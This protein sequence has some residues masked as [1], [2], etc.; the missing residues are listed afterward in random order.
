[1][2][3]RH[4]PALGRRGEG[5]V[6]GQLLFVAA[7]FLSPLT[8]RAWAAGGWAV[9]GD[10]VGATLLALGVSLLAWAARRLGSALPPFPAP[11]QQQG[12]VRTTGPYALVRHPMY[13]GAILIAAGW[14]LLFATALGLG[15]TVVLALFFALKARREEVWLRERLDGYAAYCERTP[16]RLLPFL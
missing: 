9:A 16:R 3:A 6:A 5:W 1:M 2:S 13:T 12:A 11:R 10:A 15:L 7:V 8:G 4:L 14:S